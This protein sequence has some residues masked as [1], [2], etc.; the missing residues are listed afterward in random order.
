ME[1]CNV[2]PKR[3]EVGTL[4]CCSCNCSCSSAGRIRIFENCAVRTIETQ[5]GMVSGVIT[6]LGTVRANAVVC[7]GGPGPPPFPLLILA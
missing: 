5:A 7:A 4:Y 3:W 1:V 6:E 2:H